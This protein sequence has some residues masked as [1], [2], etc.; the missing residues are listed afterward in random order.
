[1]YKYPLHTITALTIIFAFSSVLVATGP[2]DQKIHMPDEIIKIIEGGHSVFQG[3]IA[4]VAGGGVIN[5]EIVAV[6]LR[7][8]PA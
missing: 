1:M 8:D 7:S 2:N 4:G 6:A 5:D 3:G